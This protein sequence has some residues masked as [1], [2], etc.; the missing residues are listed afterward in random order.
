MHRA[1]RTGIVRSVGLLG[2]A[3]LGPGALGAQGVGSS[4]T[5]RRLEDSGRVIVKEGELTP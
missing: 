3:L 1:Q 4:E 5:M 2:L